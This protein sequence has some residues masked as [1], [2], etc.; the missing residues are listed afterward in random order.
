[1]SGG[2]CTPPA[3]GATTGAP[4]QLVG[5]PDSSILPLPRCWV[6]RGTARP[7][8]W[9]AARR[10]STLSGHSVSLSLPGRRPEFRT[11]RGGLPGRRG[12]RSRRVVPQ[13]S[14]RRPSVRDATAEQEPTRQGEPARVHVRLRAAQRLRTVCRPGTTPP[15]S[16][17]RPAAPAPSPPPPPPSHVPAQCSG[18]SP[19]TLF[20]SLSTPRCTSTSTASTARCLTFQSAPLRTR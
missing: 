12:G 17:P 19:L 20:A 4:H 3:R 6:S 15:P 9:D 8:L 1:M 2:A 10:S 7:M 11:E 14:A 18:L 16:H 5:L 13:R